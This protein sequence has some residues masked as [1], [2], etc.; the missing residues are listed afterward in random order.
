ME[1]SVIVGLL[2]IAAVWSVYLIPAVFG[3]RRDGAMSSTEEFDKWTHSMA[4][5][6]KHTASDL[7]QSSRDRI[8]SRRRRVLAAL[9]ALVTFSLF[10]AWQTSSFAW[11][12]SALFFSSLI[13]LY[14]VLLT[15]MRQ[16]RDQRLKVTHV[17]ERQTEWE[18]PQVKVV[19]S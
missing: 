11:V 15:Q 6:Q 9:S 8:R 7:A 16:R 5:V 4:H 18:E 12:L 17:A 10:L 13:G 1:T 14:L 19:G 2:V 3:E